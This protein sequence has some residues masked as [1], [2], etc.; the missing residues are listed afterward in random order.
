MPSGFGKSPLRHSVGSLSAETGRF[1]R[2]AIPDFEV[3]N[4][5]SGFDD[6]A[7]RLV[8]QHLRLLDEAVTDPTMRVRMQLPTRA[9]TKTDVE[10]VKRPGTNIT[11]TDS[12]HF[13]LDQHVVGTDLRDGH[14]ANLDGRRL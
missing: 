4:V 10:P 1:N 5:D 2:D 11:T 9:S 7:G 14:I 6:R 8:T 3:C 13:N 12:S